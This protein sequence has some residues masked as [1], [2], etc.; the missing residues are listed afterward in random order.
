MGRGRKKN[1]PQPRVYNAVTMNEGEDIRTFVSRVGG[2]PSRVWLPPF[3]IGPEI[4]SF[5][6]AHGYTTKIVS[7]LFDRHN[8]N[9]SDVCDAYK[10]VTRRAESNP[11]TMHYIVTSVTNMEAVSGYLDVLLGIGEELMGTEIDGHICAH[12]LAMLHA[13]VLMGEFQLLLHNI[14]SPHVVAAKLQCFEPSGECPICMEEF[15]NVETLTPF[16]CGH[17]LCI[18]CGQK[19]MDCCPMCRNTKRMMGTVVEVNAK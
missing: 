7:A 4:E 12:G 3:D 14:K 9:G 15:G 18:T 13:V 5:A 19:E 1:K 11:T 8:A 6:K 2:L 10:I 16:H 17:Q